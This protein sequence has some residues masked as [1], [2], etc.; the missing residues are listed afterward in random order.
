MTGGRDVAYIAQLQQMPELSGNPFIPQIFQ[1]FDADH[2]GAVNIDE[3]T[4]GVEYLATLGDPEEQFKCMQGSIQTCTD[5]TPDKL[6]VFQLRSR[7]TIPM[8]T[9]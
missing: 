5:T 7:C 2:D 3:F 8:V 4:K 1:L 9:V 6:I